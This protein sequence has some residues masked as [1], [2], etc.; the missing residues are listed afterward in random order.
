MTTTS[1]TLAPRASVSCRLGPLLSADL[2]V[3]RSG[4]SSRRAPDSFPLVVVVVGLRSSTARRACKT[5]DD[6]TRRLAGAHILELGQN[7]HEHEAKVG[8][9]GPFVTERTSLPTTRVEIVESTTNV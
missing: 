5:I 4:F 9:S 6:V 7:A 8:G 2:T 3:P 1:R